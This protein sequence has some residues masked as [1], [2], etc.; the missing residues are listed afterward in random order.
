ML[1]P[2]EHFIEAPYGFSES[3]KEQGAVVCNPTY[4]A[5][6]KEVEKQ[7][8]THGICVTVT[9]FPERKSSGNSRGNGWKIAVSCR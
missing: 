5:Y 9:G 2:G 3:E 8:A 1:V 7:L 4:A 6:E